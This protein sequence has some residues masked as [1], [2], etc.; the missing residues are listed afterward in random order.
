M[1]DLGDDLFGSSRKDIIAEQG[2][3]H[4][5]LL[6]CDMHCMHTVNDVEAGH[7]K[8][9]HICLHMYMYICM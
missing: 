4:D 9:V 2:A 5:Y 3:K 8:R 6:R 1:Q 7:G